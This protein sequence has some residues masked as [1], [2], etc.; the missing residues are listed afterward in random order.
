MK[1]NCMLILLFLFMLILLFEKIFVYSQSSNS[2]MIF[3]IYGNEKITLNK[4]RIDPVLMSELKQ[5][6]IL[7]IPAGLEITI[8]FYSDR[9]KEKIRG[10]AT[11]KILKDSAEIISG[12]LNTVK[13]IPKKGAFFFPGKKYIKG[14][15]IGATT[16]KFIIPEDNLLKYN[17]FQPLL[18]FPDVKDKNPVFK[19]VDFKKNAQ[20]NFEIMSVKNEKPD[21]ILVNKK[22]IIKDYYQCSKN[23]FEFKKGEKYFSRISYSKE[24]F[25]DDNDSSTCFFRLLTDSELN[26][27]VKKKDFF[28]Y[29]IKEDPENPDIYSIMAQIYFESELYSEA[30][31]LLLKLNKLLP[32]NKE[33]YKKLAVTYLKTGNYEEADIWEDYYFGLKKLLIR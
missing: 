17:D 4:N 26:E 16:L 22:N 24:V 29:L 15:E 14:S 25:S 11:V 19:W 23:D 30:L 31:P 27:I 2:A 10:E 28:E 6:D 8:L 21:K 13:I 3:D 9:H 12:N 5:G 20:Y 1:K 32:E 18:V 7:T 33:I